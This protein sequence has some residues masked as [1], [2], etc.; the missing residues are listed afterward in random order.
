MCAANQSADPSDT[1]LG[2]AVR[3]F[4]NA[5]DA[6]R[7]TDATRKPFAEVVTQIAPLTTSGKHRL[8]AL[9]LRA[10]ACWFGGMYD[11]ALADLDEL[12]LCYPHG[13]PGFMTAHTPLELRGMTYVKLGRFAEGEQDLLQAL[14]EFRSSLERFPGGRIER[15]NQYFWVLVARHRGNESAAIDEQGKYY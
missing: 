9:L 3:S 15:T 11:T 12:V 2:A 8:K 1:L 7:D 5:L 14:E 6:W 13:V 4:Q 10:E